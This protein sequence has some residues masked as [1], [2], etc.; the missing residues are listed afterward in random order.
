MRWSAF[1]CVVLA[2]AALQAQPQ[3]PQ[4]SAP[5]PQPTFRAE[6]NL[7]RV[8]VAVVDRHGEPVT[9]LTADDFTIEEDGDPQRVE[10]FKFVAADGQPRAGD[11]VSLEIRSPEHAAAEAARDDVRLFVIFWDEYH[12]GRF[13]SAIHARQ[14]LTSVVASAFAPMDLVALMDPLLPVDALR[15]TRDRTEIADRIRKLE[16]RLGVYV[17]TRSAIEEAQMQ[18]RDAARVRAEVTI[19][20][21]RSAA[22]HLGSLKEG[23]KAIILVSEGNFALGLEDLRQLDELA[24]AANTNNTAIYTVDPRGL[25]GGASALLRTIADRTGG[26]AF[27]SNNA[28]ERALLQV[29]KDASAFYLLGYSSIRDPQDGKF[30]SIKVRVNR[31]G[32]T[33][34]NRRGYWAPTPAERERA[35]ADAAASE[36]IPA[37]VTD[38]LAL[39]SAARPERTVDIWTGVD[40]GADGVAV[41]TAA[42]TARA[43]PGGG[44]GGAADTVSITARGIGED[45]VFEAPLAAGQL[46]FASPPGALQLRTLI[47]DHDGNTVDEDTRPVTVPDYSRATLAIGVPVVYRVRNAA[48]ARAIGAGAD[49]APFAGREFVRTDRLFVRFRVYGTA[50]GAAVKAHLTNRSGT[51]LRGLPVVAMPGGGEGMYQIEWPLS[52]QA[53]GD[54]LIAIEANGGDERA[55]MLVPLRVVP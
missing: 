14:A 18:R 54:Y 26:E 10:S 38:A 3:P 2:A 37:D 55:R 46:S 17:P 40:R 22:V 42:W 1:S 13:A 4:Q 15:F 47:R 35:R 32:V 45:R 5:A 53:R 43:A 25:V 36:A 41:V 11:D 21:V 16:G 19:S 23:R 12:I 6:S 34:R 33:V 48:E 30:H 27:L 28:P 20:A 9:S 7:V 50:A 49:P 52:S 24:E 39:L 29:I 51:A 8:D 31:R 44:R